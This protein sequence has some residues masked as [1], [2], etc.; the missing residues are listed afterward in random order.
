MRS[1]DAST[2]DYCGLVCG[3]D[4][5]VE[6]YQLDNIAISRRVNRLWRYKLMRGDLTVASKDQFSSRAAAIMEG[7][8]RA[9]EIAPNG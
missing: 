8:F 4:L 2:D 9:L 1:T 3:L 7:T 5:L 6:C